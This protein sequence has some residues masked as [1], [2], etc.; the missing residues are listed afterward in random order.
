M[1][2]VAG[3]RAAI[4]K[5]SRLAIILEVRLEDDE[6]S[7]LIFMDGIGLGR[8]VGLFSGSRRTIPNGTPR[9]GKNLDQVFEG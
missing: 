1:K 5:A 7:S 9:G 2:R 3:A 4:L 8:S 6:F